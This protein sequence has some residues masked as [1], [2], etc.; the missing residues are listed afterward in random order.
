M[1]GFEFNVGGIITHNHIIWLMNE[2]V[3]FFAS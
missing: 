2:D 3:L 1:Y